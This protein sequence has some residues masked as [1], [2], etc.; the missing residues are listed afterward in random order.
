LNRDLAMCLDKLYS[1]ID[2]KR[3]E[4]LEAHLRDT[5]II[6]T[7]ML[8]DVSKTLQVKLRYLYAYY[9]LGSLS[10]H[11]LDM[12]PLCIVFAQA[13]H[14]IGKAGDIYQK[15]CREVL[16]G[17]RDSAF[18]TGHEI[19][20]SAIMYRILESLKEE[21]PE[22]L[23]LASLFA[24][25]VLQHHHAMRTVRELIF[26]KA[27]TMLQD[28]KA[29]W[30]LDCEP[31]D[32]VRVLEKTLQEVQEITGVKVYD[33]FIQFNLRDKARSILQEYSQL[34][35]TYC[36]RLIEENILRYI[37]PVSRLLP[38]VTSVIVIPDRLVAKINRGGSPTRLEGEFLR[39]VYESE[40]YR[41]VRIPNDVLSRLK[42]LYDLYLKPSGKK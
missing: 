34:R 31:E 5:A 2:A 39:L 30:R 14:D 33:I 38:I 24:T 15:V 19:F 26:S 4:S 28:G 37:V 32:V 25:A 23:P 9:M 20:S 40:K 3:S 22:I 21:F 7:L 6:G 27:V 10:Q 36:I 41:N 35:V 18:F 42:R 29:V 13:L 17:K 8:L 12:V 11:I 1:F 16:E